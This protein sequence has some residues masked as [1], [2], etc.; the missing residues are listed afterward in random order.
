MKA[1]ERTSWSTT[2]TAIRFDEAEHRYYLPLKDGTEREILGVTRA[3]AI[4]G[5]RGEWGRDDQAAIL[6]T[7]VHKMAALYLE[8]RL[9]EE[10]L[11]PILAGFLVGIKAFLAEARV[12]KWTAIEQKV[13]D[14]AIGV[15]GTLDAI[16]IGSR[17]YNG[18]ILIDWKSGSSVAPWMELQTAGYEYLSRRVALL[19]YDKRVTRLVV[20]LRRNG[21]FS[22]Y[23]H[24]R[25]SDVAA[26][27]GMASFA[28]WKIR[29]GLAKI[30]EPED[31]EPEG[32]KWVAQPQI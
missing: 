27:M 12:R 25:R 23:E 26:F 24:K 6:G 16:G 22:V 10:A 32:I 7:K 30:Y 14:P 28:W 4:A 18:T 31:E 29:A 5:P 19:D 8:G 3:L 17:R 20:R 2:Q 15:A 1:S 11:H 21:L 13:H 9:N